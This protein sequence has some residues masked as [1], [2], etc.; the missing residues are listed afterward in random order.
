[1]THS[2]QYYYTRRV[3]SKY[4]GM[5]AKE[6]R[7]MPEFMLNGRIHYHGW[8]DINDEA[9]W[10]M[11]LKLL[12]D[13]CGRV[14]LEY[15]LTEK[16]YNY[17]NKSLVA[18]RKILKFKPDISLS[19]TAD[20]YKQWIKDN[21]EQPTIV[22]FDIKSK[23]LKKVLPSSDSLSAP[24]SMKQMPPIEKYYLYTKDDIDYYT[25]LPPLITPV[26]I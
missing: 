6:F 17:M 19:V 9:K 16:W 7:F 12:R 26:K 5:S 23:T 14:K 22:D 24:P 15:N 10:Q 11:S 1:M 3:I 18:T 13:K 4:I 25:S 21:S 20:D 2:A 8:I